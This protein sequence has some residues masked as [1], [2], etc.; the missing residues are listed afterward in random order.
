MLCD[1]YLPNLEQSTKHGGIIV[2]KPL[3]HITKSHFILAI[4][5]G[6]LL[7]IRVSLEFFLFFTFDNYIDYTSRI[8]ILKSSV[9]F[10]SSVSLIYWFLI[11]ASL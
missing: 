8:V 3:W 11:K 4:L 9:V 7:L 5:S 1:Q 6:Q 10:L 2:P